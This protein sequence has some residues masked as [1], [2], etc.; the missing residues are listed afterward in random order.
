LRIH[1][2]AELEAIT[3]GLNAALSLLAEGSR[4]VV[5]AY[6][7]LEDRIVKSVLREAARTCDCPRIYERCICGANPRGRLVYKRILRP[8]DAETQVNPRA[9]AARMRVFEKRVIPSPWSTS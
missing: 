1:S 8:T 9:A 3:Q 2:N 6:H 7:S 5:V 4:L